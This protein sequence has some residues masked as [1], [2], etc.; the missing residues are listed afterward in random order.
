MATINWVIVFLFLAGLYKIVWW[1]LKDT[2]ANTSG[3]L[4]LSQTLLGTPGRFIRSC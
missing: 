1:I 3:Y 4:L 2:I